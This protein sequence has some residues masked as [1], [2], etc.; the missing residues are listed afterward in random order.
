MRQIKT[1][2]D[3]EKKYVIIDAAM[4][5]LDLLKKHPFLT[6]AGNAGCGKTA[7][8]RHLALHFMS[9]GYEIVPV[10]EPKTIVEYHDET[11]KQVFVLDDVCGVHTVDQQKRGA[12]LDYGQV[13]QDC[14]LQSGALLLVSVRLSI[15][16][17]ESLHDLKVLSQNVINLKDK[18]YALSLKTRQDIFRSY[19]KKGYEE[20]GITDKSLNS[21]DA[22]PLLCRFSSRSLY[23]VEDNE[24]ENLDSNSENIINDL[25]TFFQTPIQVIECEIKSLRINSPVSYCVLV[26]CLLFNG[27]LPKQDLFHSNRYKKLL[28][29][30]YSVCGLNRGTSIKTVYDIFQS[31]KDVYLKEVDGTFMFIH[32]IIMDIVSV[33][34]GKHSPN[35]ILKHANI[36][37]IIERVQLKKNTETIGYKIFIPKDH[38]FDFFQ[39]LYTEIK[40]GNV[41]QIFNHCQLE[42]QWVQR[43]FTNY[44]EKKSNDELR[45]IF[46]LVEDKKGD[47]NQ[48]LRLKLMDIWA[49]TLD[50]NPVNLEFQSYL[51]FIVNTAFHCLL[52]KGLFEIIELLERRVCSDVYNELFKADSACTLIAILGGDLNIYSWILNVQ[53]KRTSWRN[54]R[55]KLLQNTFLIQDFQW[56][57]VT[58][59]TNIVE[60]LLHYDICITCLNE[61]ITSDDLLHIIGKLFGFSVYKE[62]VKLFLTKFIQKNILNLNCGVEWSD[63]N[64]DN[65]I[66]YYR[67]VGYMLFFTKDDNF[68]KLIY[69][70]FNSDVQPIVIKLFQHRVEFQCPQFPLPKTIGDEF[71]GR[72]KVRP[73]C[74]ALAAI[75]GHE[76]VVNLLLLNGSN[77]NKINIPSN[78]VAKSR[79]ALPV[80]YAA[81]YGRLSIVRNL[82]QNGAN[83]ESTG[84]MGCTLLI[85]ASSYGHYDLA[86]FLLDKHVHINAT[87]MFQ[88]TALLYGSKKGHINIVNLLLEKG[89]ITNTACFKSSTPLIEASSRGHQEI[90]DNLLCHNA[91]VNACDNENRTSLIKAA[92]NGHCKIVKRLLERQADIYIRSHE[93][94][95]ALMVASR[96]GHLKVVSILMENIYANLHKYYITKEKELSTQENAYRRAFARLPYAFCSP[97]ITEVSEEINQAFSKAYRCGHIDIMTFLLDNGANV[98]QVKSRTSRSLLNDAVFRGKYRIVN[99]LLKN[100]AQVQ[101]RAN[102]GIPPLMLAS[103]KGHTDIVKLL[104]TYGSNINST[105]EHIPILCTLKEGIWIRQN[106]NESKFNDKNGTALIC[107]IQKGAS[108]KLIE[109]LLHEKHININSQ[110]HMGR[111]ALMI[112]CGSCRAKVVNLLLHYKPDLNIRSDVGATA[113]DIASVRE[114]RNENIIKDLLRN[115]AMYC[116]DMIPFQEGYQVCPVRSSISQI[117][118]DIKWIIS[119]IIIILGLLTLLPLCE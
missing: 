78:N 73:T 46:F 10:I 35:I 13:I 89:A 84:P 38:H 94:E 64:L 111:T 52:G 8:I 119:R 103:F 93:N 14:V 34:F 86:K 77:P 18:K 2:I 4:D 62:R 80:V 36:E 83:I 1:W 16:N 91:S 114:F 23:I 112:A 70:K 108:L 61:S 55:Y 45:S 19:F 59:R 105:S 31:L 76:A 109:T 58:G 37:V 107:A 82:L 85:F 53:K 115:G 92:E 68:N 57:V 74:I 99:L 104:L 81:M 48:K 25:D 39:R 98:R 102:S 17:S 106:S 67:K 6:V 15:L 101:K 79:T 3:D 60:C 116:R 27:R 32:D 21:H 96:K 65:F 43:A 33:C 51:D 113:L 63:F 117:E 22:F 28:K 41:W 26:L 87:N 66:M 71:Q 50:I 29:D 110:T 12:W 75:L 47:R 118:F 56:A 20:L 9:Q 40:M 90:V 88:N 30:C 7:L 69:K 72:M 97:P 49:Q 100:G 5:A 42:I 11:R 24:E 95:T 54:L 44:L